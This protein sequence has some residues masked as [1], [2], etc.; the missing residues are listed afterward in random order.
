MYLDEVLAAQKRGEARGIPSVCSAH[1]VVIRQTLKVFGKH[2]GS[3]LTGE[4]MPGV[5][6]LIESTCNQVNQYG[7]YTGMTPADFVEYV[8]GIADEVAV[9]LEKIILGGDHLGPSVWQ[10]ESA[11]AAMQKAEVMVR[12]YVQAGFTK[13]HIDCS[14]K[15]GDDPPG[16]LDSEVIAQRAARLAKA[17]EDAFTRSASP[18]RYVIG[19]EVPIPGGA[20]AHE[21]GVSVTTVD[22]VRE[23]I[24]VTHKAFLGKAL[25][26]AWDRVIAVVVQPGVEFGDDFVLPYQP[27]AARELSHFIAMQPLVYEAHSTDYQTREALRNL[28]RDHFAILK[29]GPGLTFSYREA[30]FSLAMIEDQMFPVDERSHLIEVLDQVMVERPEYWKK[31]YFGSEAEQAYKRKFS[32]S[33]RARYYWLQPEVHDAVHRLMGNLGE[34]TLPR[35]LLSQFVGELGL[36]AGEVIQW[37]ISNVLQDYATACSG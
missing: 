3:A 2:P 36:N 24:T 18:L 23:T 13:I 34:K 27:D 28:V 35:E 25:R 22:A 1:P 4:E 37:K 16:T 11:E 12:E 10:S 32:L 30:I 26:D 9:P 31:Y 14:M 5:S 29:V 33:D 8:R 20:T 17:A 21:E 19:S 15:L 7:G 6:P